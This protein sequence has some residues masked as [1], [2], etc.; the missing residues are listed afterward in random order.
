MNMLETIVGGLLWELRD[1]MHENHAQWPDNR[2][3][4]RKLN[5]ITQEKNEEV[6]TTF[7]EIIGMIKR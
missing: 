1:D 7:V 3:M 4:S 5:S 2:A 6:R